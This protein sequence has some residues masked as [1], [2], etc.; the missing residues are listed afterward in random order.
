MVIA[1]I[2]CDRT[3]ER[4]KRQRCFKSKM[5]S[6][7]SALLP[8]IDDA[9]DVYEADPVPH[10]ASDGPSAAEEVET[11]D[12]AHPR[13]SLGAA[14]KKFGN[15]VVD[16]RNADFGGMRGYRVAEREVYGDDV[17]AETPAEMLARLTREV[18]SLKAHLGTAASNAIQDDVNSRKRALVDGVKSLEADLA[19][20]EA[21]RGGM[22]GFATA[23]QAARDALMK[24]LAT[25]KDSKAT[26]DQTT[27]TKGSEGTAPA[28]GKLT[29]ELYLD[30]AL[31]TSQ[32]IATLGDLDSRLAALEKVLGPV[33][34]TDADSVVSP[35]GGVQSSQPLLTTLEKM[36]QQLYLLTQPRALDIL[37]MK[38]KRLATDLDRIAEARTRLAVPAV[39]IG[40]S[41]PTVPGSPARGGVAGAASTD[42]AGG[43]SGSTSV[44]AAT[45]RSLFSSLSA[46]QPLVPHLPALLLRLK[47]LQQMHTDAATMLDSLSAVSEGQDRADA[48]LR[49]LKTICSRLEKS[50]SENAV[51]MQGNVE[52]LNARIEKLR[53]VVGEK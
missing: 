48:E 22:A 46:V 18:A 27:S 41:G 19:E 42:A 1:L 14:L 31:A 13:V 40:G 20:I 30:P 37:A 28:D 8:D 4:W 29:Y 7:F 45:I 33:G 53:S 49:E 43:D 5:S 24:Q 11:D 35:L 34:A 16:A 36:E 6:K 26:G 32:R 39:E 10:A 12:I 15:S 50:M 3:S 38:V 2:A 17:D 21:V 52:S 9:P 47:A 51:V 44:P 25:F 23:E